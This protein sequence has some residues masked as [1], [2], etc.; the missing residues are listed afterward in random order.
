[1]ET[2]AD[3]EMAEADGEDGAG[4]M[5]GADEEDGAGV[6]TGADEEPNAGEMTGADE[7]TG[8]GETTAVDEEANVSGMI[9]AKGEVGADEGADAAVVVPLDGAKREEKIGAEAFRNDEPKLG[10]LGLKGRGDDGVNEE[11]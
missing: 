4:G 1:M 5:T 2:A 11:G 3:G 8:T 9:D 6:M 10:L 7:K